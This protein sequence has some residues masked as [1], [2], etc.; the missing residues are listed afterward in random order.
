M[1]AEGRASTMPN[2]E[3]RQDRGH[4]MP[5]LASP[6]PLAVDRRVLRTRLSPAACVARL[7][8]VTAGAGPADKWMSGEWSLRGTVGR[9]RFVVR[10]FT[11]DMRNVGRPFVS[12]TLETDGGGTR[13]RLTFAP[14]LPFRI[15]SVFAIVALIAFAIFSV[16][17]GYIWSTVDI[18]NGEAHLPVP[19]L[20]V[21]LA[22]LFVVGPYLLKLT[23]ASEGPWLLDFLLE[24]LEAR[25]DA[26]GETAAGEGRTNGPLNWKQGPTSRDKEHR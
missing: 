23:A 10:R 26:D 17:T 13:I 15:F 19:W 3:S 1:L 7:E 12:G 14:R 11:R 25:L 22:A 18:N 16:A 5:A 9:D 4:Q 6:N 21:I 24:T 20:I 2:P 8:A